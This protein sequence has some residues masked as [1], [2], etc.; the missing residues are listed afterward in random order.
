MGC[1]KA[2]QV[3]LRRSNVVRNGPHPVARRRVMRDGPS[4]LPKK[5]CLIGNTIYLFRATANL[6]TKI[7]YSFFAS[8]TFALIVQ[9]IRGSMLDR[10][11][12]ERKD[13]VMLDLCSMLLLER[14]DKIENDD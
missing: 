7:V 12:E 13:N 6:F 11:C 5:T 8:R 4:L 9:D 10:V 2:H 3:S 1:R 14:Y